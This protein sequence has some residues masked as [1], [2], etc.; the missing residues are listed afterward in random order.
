MAYRK[1]FSIAELKNSIANQSSLSNYYEVKVSAPSGLKSDNFVT[2]ELGIRCS[3]AVLPTSAF[4]T[5]E[6]KDNFHGIN[7]QHAHTR[8]YTDINFSFYLDSNYEVIKF[9]E[10]WMNYIGGDVNP[11][12]KFRRLHYPKDYKTD[13]MSIC[14]FERGD[15]KDAELVYNFYGAFPK[16][17]D[18]IPVSYGD[19]QVLKVNVTFA[20]EYYTTNMSRMYQS[21]AVVGERGMKNEKVDREVKPKSRKPSTMADRLYGKPG[22]TIQTEGGLVTFQ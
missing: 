20:Y 12:K 2:R 16:S 9:F 10:N 18:S 17:M 15:E 5:G 13:T 4:A 11:E 8:L 7:E 1:T 14:K 3:D 21:G 19:A 22:Q 6:I